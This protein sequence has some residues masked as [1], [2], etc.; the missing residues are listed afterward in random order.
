[1]VPDDKHAITHPD[2]LIKPL[3]KA[4][5]YIYIYIHILIAGATLSVGWAFGILQAFRVRSFRVLGVG[6]RG[7]GFRV[8]GLGFR[9]RGLGF[10]GHPRP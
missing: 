5:I 9:V 4:H 2:T 7:L 6:V 3:S 1:M 8:W 10:L